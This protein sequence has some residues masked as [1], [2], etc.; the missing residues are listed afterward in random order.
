MAGR[1]ASSRTIGS[2]YLTR[3]GL[4]DLLLRAEGPDGMAGDA[5]LQAK[6]LEDGSAPPWRLSEPLLR[7]GQVVDV[8]VSD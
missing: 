7:I 6:V 4:A 1:K 2:A 5:M 8:L 3:P